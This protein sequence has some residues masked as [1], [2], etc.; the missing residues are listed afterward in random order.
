MRVDEY[1]ALDATALAAA[2]AAREV[3]AGEVGRLAE[4]AHA[5]VRAE[6]NAVVE[7]YDDPPLRPSV[8]PFAGVPFLRKDYGA[9]EAGRRTERGSRLSK[10]WVSTGTSLLMERF[11][12]AGLHV[13]GRSAVPEFILHATTESDVHGITR[14]PWNLDRSAGG[15]SGGAAAAVAAGIVPLAHASDCAGSIRIP[16]AVCGL[17]GLKP[18]RGRVP[19]GDGRTAGGW[20]GIAEEFVVARSARDAMAVLDAVGEPQPERQRHGTV[21]VGVI[22]THW[23]GLS[24][25][26]ALVDAVESVGSALAGAGHRVEGLTWP[27]AYDEVVAL[28]DPLFGAGAAGDIA[29][30]ESETGRSAEANLEPLTVEYLRRIAALPADDLAE[31]SRRGAALTTRFD[32]LLGGHDVIVCSTLGRASLPLGVLAS[33]PLDHWVEANDKYT[34]H[35]YVANLTGWPAV[36]MPWGRGPDAVPIGVQLLGRPG[37]DALLLSLVALLEQLA[38]PLGRPAV[39]SGAQSRRSTPGSTHNIS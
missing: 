19:W 9:T 3:D 2:I 6:V 14:N 8:G 21:D 26:P 27:V 25:D 11:A 34:P 39:W 31:A 13:R 35:S 4:E 37:A 38:P 22:S 29:L 1:A 15:S 10:G 28:M 20:G 36:T 16:A 5:L 7:W 24:A 33:G 30:I 18:T 12:A 32:Q 23:A 17:V